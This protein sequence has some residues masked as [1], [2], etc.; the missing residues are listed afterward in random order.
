MQNALFEKLSKEYEDLQFQND[1][2]AAWT[3]SW[4]GMWLAPLPG[5]SIPLNEFDD[6]EEYK[7]H[8]EIDDESPWMQPN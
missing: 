4:G 7:Q 6:K 2:L 8:M 5:V 1:S 3:S